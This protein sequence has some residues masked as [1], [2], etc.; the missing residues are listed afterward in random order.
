MK[1]VLLDIIQDPKTAVA[2]GAAMLA[3]V[4][5]VLGPLVQLSIGK[6][7]AAAAKQS[8]DAA[9][10]AADAAMLTAQNAGSRE[11]ARLRLAWMDKVRDTVSELHSILIGRG[12]V[13]QAKSA[14][15]LSHLG[16]QIDLL[17]NRENKLQMDLWE[18]TDKI[19]NSQSR[20]ERQSVDD[21]LIAAGRAVLK[22]EWEKIKAEMRGEPFKTGEQ[23]ARST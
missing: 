4:S 14:E 16:T 20:E 22:A 18:I 23:S 12:D 9:Q 19:Y 21:K 11:I 3:F 17:L 5:G 13:D 1:K 7:Q 10:R 6:R 8:A 15:E 2:I